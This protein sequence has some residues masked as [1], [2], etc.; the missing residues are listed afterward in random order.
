PAGFPFRERRR[1]PPVS[2]SPL[3]KVGSC[4]SSAAS[5]AARRRGSALRLCATVFLLDMAFSKGYV[6]DLDE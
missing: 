5:M 3:R 6:E 4:S 1:R 2:F